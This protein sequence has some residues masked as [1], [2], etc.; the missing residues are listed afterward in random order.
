MHVYVPDLENYKCFVVQSS[1]TIR[2]YKQVPQKNTEIEYRDYFIN[3][4]YIYKDGTQS[5]GNYTTYL[6]ICLS[7]EVV[8][9]NVFYRNDIDSILTIF[10]IMCIISFYIPIKVFTRLFRRFN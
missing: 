8:S 3:A 4:N 6:P 9:D 1:D 5:F 2:A 10:C 7:T